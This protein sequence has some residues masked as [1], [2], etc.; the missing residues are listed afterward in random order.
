M[1]LA[2]GLSSVSGP[3]KI[4]KFREVLTED[5]S[6]H[7][8]I[9]LVFESFERSLAEEISLLKSKGLNLLAYMD[10]FFTEI[11]EL[12][13]SLSRNGIKQKRTLK[14][15]EFVQVGKDWKLHSLN[16]FSLDMGGSVCVREEWLEELRSEFRRIIG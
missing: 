4:L 16:G 6:D 14:L 11:R 15:E 2:D 13:L 3:L 9:I 7:K 1:Q 8:N 12:L 5:I 10:R